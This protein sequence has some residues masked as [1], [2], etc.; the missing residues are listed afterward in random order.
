MRADLDPQNPFNW[1][2]RKKVAN[3]ATG[4]LIGALT[5]VNCTS[6]APM[7]VEGAEWF[8]VS[9]ELFELS[10]TVMLLAISF[11]PLVLAPL[12]ESLGRMWIY[13]VTSIVL[14]YLA[15]SAELLL[16]IDQQRAHVFATILVTFVFWSPRLS[17]SGKAKYV[18]CKVC[19]TFRSKVSAARSETP[20]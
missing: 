2:T 10:F 9:R 4:F 12:S 3:A 20:L 17:R 11:G 6:V 1:P 14:V 13:Q 5:A 19:L 15:S 7:A 8:G 18:P 16:M